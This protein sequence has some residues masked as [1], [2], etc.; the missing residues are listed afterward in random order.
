MTIYPLML[1]WTNIVPDLKLDT[2]LGIYA[3]TG[4]YDKRALASVGKNYWTFEPGVMASWLSS[5][6][7]TEVTLYTGIDFN[8]ENTASD[9]TSGTSLHLDLTVAQ[10]L[11][12]DER[13]RARAAAAASSRPPARLP[14]WPVTV[15]P[16]IAPYAALQRRGRR[17]ES[18]VHEMLSI[19]L[20]AKRPIAAE[21]SVR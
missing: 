20:L 4:E 13:F 7:G 10:H 16:Q 9:Y 2:R 8:T 5:K 3:P 18:E 15:Q 6:I 21:A 11:P 1:G 12:V 19:G 17:N 14:A